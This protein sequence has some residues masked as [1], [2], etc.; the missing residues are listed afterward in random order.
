MPQEVVPDGVAVAEGV[1]RERA[2]A[3]VV[4]PVGAALGWREERR[5]REVAAA[6]PA[7]KK[8]GGEGVGMGALEVGEPEEARGAGEELLPEGVVVAEGE[9][10]GGGAALAGE[11]EGGA[12]EG[13]AGGRGRGGEGW[14][15]GGCVWWGR[16]AVRDWVGGTREGGRRAAAA[17]APAALGAGGEL[18]EAAGG[19]GGVRGELRGGGLKGGARLGAEPAVGGGEGEEGGAEGPQ[20]GEAGRG[21]RRG[22]TAW[23]WH[24]RCAAVCSGAGAERK[25]I[26]LG[27]GGSVGFRSQVDGWRAGRGQA[28]VLQAPAA[29][30]VN[31]GLLRGGIAAWSEPRTK[32]CR[33]VTQ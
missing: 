1:R 7:E 3:V 18:P 12:D 30:A 6:L 23:C 10:D 33:P 26:R 20:L 9:G 5:V 14:V 22:R 25:G 16:E 21:G 15:R 19:R 2:R 13:A 29:R 28:H 27:G 17:R 31:H 24:G 11:G 8:G 32:C 4:A